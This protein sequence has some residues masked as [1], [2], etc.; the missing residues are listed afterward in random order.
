MTRVREREIDPGVKSYDEAFESFRWQVPEFYNIAEDACDRH[1]ENSALAGRTALFYEDHTGHEERY[2]FAEL[3]ERSDKLALVLAERGIGRGDRVAILMPQRP[4]TALTHLAGYKLGAITVPLTVLFRRDA[5]SFRLEDSGTR[6]I[7][8]EEESLPLLEE[9]LP[10]LPEL[11]T[12]LVVG[13]PPAW[14]AEAEL[15]DFWSAVRQAE[16]P[17]RRVNTRADDPALLVYTS[18]TTGNPKGALHAHRYL[19]GHLTGFEFAHNLTPEEGDCFWTPADWA[20]VGGLLDILLAAWHYGLPVVGYKG[21]GPFDPEQALGL[22]EKYEVR[23]AFIPPTALK[24]MAQR[25]GIRERYKVNLRSM[26]SGGEA[27]G[28][29]TLHWAEKELGVKVN[30]LYGQTEIN[31]I[32]GNCQKLWPALPGSMGRALPGHKLAIVDDEGRALPSGE[33][34]E[35]AV[36]KGDDPVFFLEYWNNPEGT[37]EKFIGDWALTGDLAVQDEEGNFWFKGR[38]DDVI[39]SAGHRIG[40]TEI[41]ESLL[42][43]PAVALSAVIASPDEL[44]GNVVKAFIR[45]A[46]GYEPSQELAAE[47]QEFVKETLARHEYPREIEFLDDFPLTTTGKIRRNELRLRDLEKKRPL[48]G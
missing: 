28:A 23:N 15:V 19:M 47:I 30:E 16:G 4:E 1:A 13:H 39:I 9:L 41:E 37:G 36:L 3:K 46:P 22:M 38:K 31:L 29:E 26:M 32:V 27:L 42:K 6:A 33:M 8:L 45:P 2:T 44:R 14:S 43:H 40:P 12:V 7:V 24:M 10:E 18:G 35:I 25:T 21:S 17:F 5:L 34:G 48:T 11:K 20:W